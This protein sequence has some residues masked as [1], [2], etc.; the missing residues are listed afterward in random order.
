M[1]PFRNRQSLGNQIKKASLVIEAFLAAQALVSSDTCGS[2]G[3]ATD[4]PQTGPV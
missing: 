2:V 1:E 4:R 3:T